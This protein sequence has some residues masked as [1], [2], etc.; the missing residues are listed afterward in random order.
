MTFSRQNSFSSFSGF[1][2]LFYFRMD[3]FLGSRSLWFTGSMTS[4]ELKPVADWMTNEH[5]RTLRRP[6][7]SVLRL[8][9]VLAAGCIAATLGFD[10]AWT[11][12]QFG[13]L[14]H[15]A[16]GLTPWTIAP[17]FVESAFRKFPAWSAII[18]SAALFFSVL[19]ACPMK[20]PRRYF[21]SA[22]LCFWQARLRYSN[23]GKGSAPQAVAT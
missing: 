7:F 22:V 15:G 11:G 17:T 12:F 23:R 3:W 16:Y 13:F 19:Y 4:S 21:I 5:A 18:L 20:R 1:A 2:E 9:A 6:A 8:A 14:F 10:F